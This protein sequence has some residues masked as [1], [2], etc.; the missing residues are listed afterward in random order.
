M[1]D[2]RRR[3]RRECRCSAPLS[4]RLWERRRLTVV[5]SDVAV[6]DCLVVIAWNEK[7]P[8]TKN[9]EPL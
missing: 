9:F 4:R 6:I 3:R 7:I 2:R 1:E 5:A 8:L